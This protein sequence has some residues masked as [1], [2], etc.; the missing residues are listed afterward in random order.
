MCPGPAGNNEP[1][2]LIQD[3]MLQS[4]SLIMNSSELLRQSGCIMCW[5][6]PNDSAVHAHMPKLQEIPL[7]RRLDDEL[8]QVPG[9]N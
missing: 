5:D 7:R 3:Y 6:T 4:L 9:S 1:T 8:D 2:E